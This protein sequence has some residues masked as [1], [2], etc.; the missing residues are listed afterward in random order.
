MRLSKQQAIRINCLSV[1]VSL[2]NSFQYFFTV[3]T[4]ANSVRGKDIQTP[5][6]FQQAAPYVILEIIHVD[7]PIERISQTDSALLTLTQAAVHDR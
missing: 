6:L 1:G 7:K 2:G 4:K 3:G 5:S